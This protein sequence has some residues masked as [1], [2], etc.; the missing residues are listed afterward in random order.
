MPFNFIPAEKKGVQHVEIVLLSPAKDLITFGSD[1]VMGNTVN[2]KFDAKY[3]V[4]DA[5]IMTFGMEKC[6]R[7]WEVSSNRKLSSVF[8]ILIVVDKSI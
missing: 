2:L 3:D 5:L 6:A 1:D 4:I 8:C 7:Q